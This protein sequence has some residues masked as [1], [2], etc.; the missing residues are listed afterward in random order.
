MRGLPPGDRT[1][2]DQALDWLTGHGV[3]ADPVLRDLVTQTDS[4]RLFGTFCPDADPDRLQLDVD[5][6]C[7]L[8]GT[9]PGRAGFRLA[10]AGL[11]A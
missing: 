2:G 10:W 4:A 8:V 5:W 11:P 6:C 7:R 9:G 1:D 3:L